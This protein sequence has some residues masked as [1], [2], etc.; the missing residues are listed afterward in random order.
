MI[1]NTAVSVTLAHFFVIYKRRC[2]TP[3]K[4]I[5]HRLKVSLDNFYYESIYTWLKSQ[6]TVK[7]NIVSLN[8]TEVILATTPFA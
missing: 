3:S 4:L 1:T 2:I 7:V 8:N 5:I 6:K